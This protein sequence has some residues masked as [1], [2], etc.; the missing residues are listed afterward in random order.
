MRSARS[1]RLPTARAS[2]S[3]SATLGAYAAA[4]PPATAN[5]SAVPSATLIR[6]R[7]I[8]PGCCRFAARRADEPRFLELANDASRGRG[9]GLNARLAVGSLAPRNVD[10]SGPAAAELE[11][12]GAV[13]RHVG[14]GLQERFSLSVERPLN[15]VEQL[16]Q[17]VGNVG[18]RDALPLPLLPPAAVSSRQDGGLRVDVARTDLDTNRNAAQVPLAILPT[19]LRVA[20]VDANPEAR[21]IQT[22]GEIGASLDRAL[23]AGPHDRYQDGLDRRHL[24]RNSQPAVVAVDHDQATE[25]PPRNSPRSRVGVLD[26]AVGVRELDVVGFCK[27]LPEIVRRAGL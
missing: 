10:H 17:D 5:A 12:L 6:L 27:V 15:V 7:K 13:G 21:G 22:L 16:A 3:R 9:L 2:A 8:C 19:R 18:Q 4:T 26:G 24:R 1:R 14:M 25:H 20:R 11:E 23:V